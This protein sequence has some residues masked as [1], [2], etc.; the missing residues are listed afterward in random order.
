M[1]AAQYRQV[2][3]ADGYR[4]RDP[5]YF[6]RLPWT[7]PRDPQASEWRIRQRSFRRLADDLVWT[8]GRT[9]R[10][11]DVGA[12]CGWLSHRLAADGHRLCAVDVST[13]DEDGLGACR[14]YDVPFA[15][16]Q[17]DFTA[18]PFA[19][20][21]F[22]VVVFNASLHYADQPAQALAEARRVLSANGLVAVIDSPLF[23]DPQHGEQMVQQQLARFAR[24]GVV[25][26]TRLGQG[27]LT[28]AGL[29]TM[30][31]A[32]GWTSSFIRTRGPWDWEL[33]RALAWPR[34][35]R[36][37]AAFGVWMAR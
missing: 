19:A 12:G 5:E 3:Q 22:D 23:A 6:R 1:D 33:R 11:L 10:I 21:A 7:S 37:P 17:G 16:V 13:D 20:G 24:Q 9:L 26:P 36:A 2:R 31:R 25:R 35:R 32:C 34:L 29:A 14:H 30:A 27:Y 18:L 28:Y 15:C 8:P 4:R